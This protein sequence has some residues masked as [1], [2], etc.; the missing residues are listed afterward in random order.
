[1]H[2]AHHT[3]DDADAKR[4]SSTNP[5]KSAR[6]RY[7]ASDE[8]GRVFSVRC[9][10]IADARGTVRASDSLLVQTTGTRTRHVLAIG[11]KAEVRAHPAWAS[12]EHLDLPD[13][14]V[15]P[16]LV[17]AHA[18]LDLTHIGPQPMGEGGFAAWID[19]VRR[20]RLADEGAIAASVRQGV[21]LLLRGGTVAVGDIA[22]SVNGA[23][24]V[25]PARVLDEAQMSGVSF[26]EFFGL[27]VDGSPGVDAALERA[28]GVQPDTVQLGLSPHAP[29]SVSLGGYARAREAGLP[30]CTHL[31]ESLSERAMIAEATGPI[32]HFLEGL[33]QWTPE[34][35]AQF[36]SGKS[37]VQ[38]TAPELEGALTVHLNDLN[39]AD[40]QCLARIG[41]RAVYCPRASTYF[42]AP[43]AF[44]PHRYRELLRA[45][46]PVALGTDS[47]IN[48]PASDVGDRGICVLDEARLLHE[49]DGADPS[50]L[51][52]MLYRHAPNV[53]G[54]P[55]QVLQ[56]ERDL[57]GLISVADESGDAGWGLV[58]SRGPIAFL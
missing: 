54:L 39:E 3:S 13:R 37:P 8:P 27:S 34:I 45:G 31:A 38:F 12:A 41:A 22:G 18:H 42:G 50:A 46:V 7:A 43:E 25:A 26:L 5:A 24:S 9:A 33:G 51:L 48:L 6:S 14:I 44:G 23:P 2:E 56:A 11:A 29:Y 30:I 53:L 58:A 15:A 49:R 47:V 1:M 10:G 35:A 52:E 28:A 36:G 17:N 57:L 4:G 21:D 16:A 40:T 32:R 20:G 55:E 19:M